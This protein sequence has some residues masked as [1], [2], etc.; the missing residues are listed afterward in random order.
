MTGVAFDHDAGGGGHFRPHLAALLSAR[1]LGDMTTERKPSD[2]LRE[3]LGL[4]FRAAAGA[5]REG[6]REVTKEVDIAKAARTAGTFAEQASKEIARV[7]LLFGQTFER[8][9]AVR[10]K[11]DPPR[12]VET[13]APEPT[14]SEGEP[15]EPK[16]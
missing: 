5:M 6:V 15:G 2:D 8:E 13:E 14:P 16:D 9:I 12:A 7:A 11:S 1:T 4:I 3:G 10:P